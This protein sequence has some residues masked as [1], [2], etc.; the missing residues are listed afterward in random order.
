MPAV[1]RSMAPF[2]VGRGPTTLCSGIEILVRRHRSTRDKASEL[3]SS[4]PARL[5][6]AA[7]DGRFRFADW[8]ITAPDRYFA[9]GTQFQTCQAF[10]HKLSSLTRFRAHQECSTR[11]RR[12]LHRTAADKWRAAAV[13]VESCGETHR[14][15]LNEMEMVGVKR[16]FE[17]RSRIEQAEKSREA[18]SKSGEIGSVQTG[19]NGKHERPVGI[20]ISLIQWPS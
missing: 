15:T 11:T 17:F 13:N 20:G 2:K 16:R 4:Q 7:L 6:I 19:N 1:P 3:L 12:G 10:D 18:H 5:D 8:P 9:C 14:P